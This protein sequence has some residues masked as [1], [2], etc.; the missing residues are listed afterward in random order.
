M[1]RLWAQL[2]RHRRAKLDR[3]AIFDFDEARKA[4]LREITAGEIVDAPPPNNAIRIT[5]ELFAKYVVR[6]IDDYY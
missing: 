6:F 3:R 4:Y 1:Y 2:L 5:E